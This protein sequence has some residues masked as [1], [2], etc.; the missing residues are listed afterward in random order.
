ME[1]V[2]SLNQIIRLS[3][4]GLGLIV[5]RFKDAARLSTVEPV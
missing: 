3:D 2:K 5:S 1:F 4:G